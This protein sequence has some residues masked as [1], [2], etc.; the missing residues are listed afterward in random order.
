M[1]PEV[2]SDD[3]K[4]PELFLGFDFSTQQAKAVVVDCDLKV[5]HEVFVPYDST[6]PEF[7]LD[8]YSLPILII[9]VFQWKYFR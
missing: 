8:L 2:K 6:F 3:D 4:E 9:L 7:R 1:D 5:T